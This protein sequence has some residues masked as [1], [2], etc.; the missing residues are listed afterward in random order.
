MSYQYVQVD[1][2][3]RFRNMYD[4]VSKEQSKKYKEGSILY[5]Q[6]IVEKAM[7][8]LKGIN[9]SDFDILTKWFRTQDENDHQYQILN[10]ISN[11]ANCSRL[12]SP[13]IPNY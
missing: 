12:K 11:L 13:R 4:L 7:I 9:Q 2:V 8:F 5:Y 6:G 3:T 1:I 10:E